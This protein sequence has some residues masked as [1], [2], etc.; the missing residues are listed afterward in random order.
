[1]VK[2]CSPYMLSIERWNEWKQFFK[3][4]E[5]KNEVMT[6]LEFFFNSE[7]CFHSVHFCLPNYLDGSINKMFS[8]IIKCP[9]F[10]V[11]RQ[12]LS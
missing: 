3:S 9:L 7:F 6:P 8:Y 2:L 5:F 1:M 10:L 12:M 11:I 4:R